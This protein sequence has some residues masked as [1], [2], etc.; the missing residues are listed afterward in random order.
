LNGGTKEGHWDSVRRDST[1]S[2]DDNDGVLVI[3]GK[4]YDTV[5]NNNK[6]GKISII[7][8]VILVIKQAARKKQ[9]LLFGRKH[10]KDIDI[11]IQLL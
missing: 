4:E 1:T 6:T 2:R 9:K 5:V 11:Y 10:E 7:S 8:R 3:I